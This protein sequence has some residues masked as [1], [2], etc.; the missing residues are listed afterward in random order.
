MRQRWCGQANDLGSVVMAAQRNGT[1][2]VRLGHEL[3]SLCRSH[4]STLQREA[5]L[6]GRRQGRVVAGLGVAEKT[7]GVDMQPDRIHH[8]AWQHRPQERQHLVLVQVV[9]T[10]G[11]VGVLLFE[12]QV[13]KVV[14]QA[15]HDQ[16]VVATMALGQPR[17]LQR[18]LELADRFAAV[19]RLAL[20]LEQRA[21]FFNIKWYAGQRAQKV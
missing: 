10:I 13:P 16:C 17:R 4:Q 9:L 11:K 20:L 7:L 2:S 14:Q 8:F 1:L 5:A 19:Q 6:R 15:G 18:M 12:Q 3:R 21:D